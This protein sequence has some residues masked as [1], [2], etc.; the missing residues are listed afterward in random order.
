M[1]A[2]GNRRSNDFFAVPI[3]GSRIYL[4]NALIQRKI[5]SF[6]GLFEWNS[7]QIHRTETE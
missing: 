5:K 4:V 6:P 1:P 7:G 3:A 2:M